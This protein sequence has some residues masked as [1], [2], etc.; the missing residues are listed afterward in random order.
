MG[1]IPMPPGKIESGEILLR[2]ED[3]LKKS[4]NEFH[5]HC[6][7]DIAMIF[8]E[9]MTALNPVIK[10][11]HQIEEML[12]IHFSMTKQERKDRVVELLAYALTDFPQPDSP[13]MHSVL[14]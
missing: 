8:Q 5:R 3:L 9:P 14:P 4:K 13:T 11:G 1:L 7:K 2:N 10:I 6:G 12:K